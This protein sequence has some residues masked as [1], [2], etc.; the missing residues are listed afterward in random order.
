MGVYGYGS[1]P[2]SLIP[3]GYI[4]VK[5]ADKHGQDRVVN[6]LHPAY[7]GSIYHM[8]KTQDALFFQFYNKN[9]KLRITDLHQGIIWGLQ[10]AE[11]ALD[12]RLVNRFDFD[13]DYGTVLN[14]FLMQ[15]ACD[16]PLTVYGSGGQTRAF[17]HIENSMDCIVLAMQNPPAPHD[18]VKIYNQMT[19]TLTVIE[20]AKLIQR[21]F[22]SA[23]HKVSVQFLDNPRKEL[24][25]NDLTVSNQQFLALGLKP[26]HLSSTTLHKIVAYLK[27]QHRAKDTT[28]L[29]M[30][31]IL[32]SSKW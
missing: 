5:M 23:S 29:D 22:S 25:A 6:I 19:E 9:W 24:S 16:I 32:P 17:I 4:D 3:E 14:R 7:G 20:L 26:I 12:A 30:Q 27:L 10:T 8:T 2:D 1:I 11:T 18:K 15:T 21:E 13:G 31:H 28:K